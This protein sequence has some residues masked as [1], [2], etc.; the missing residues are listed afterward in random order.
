MIGSGSIVLLAGLLR[1]G[2]EMLIYT[3]Q[4]AS[5]T[6]IVRVSPDEAPLKTRGKTKRDL[7]L[8]DQE[9]LSESRL[10]DGAPATALTFRQGRALYKDRKKQVTVN[11]LTPTTRNLYRLVVEKGRFIDDDDIR[12]RRRVAVV[13]QDVWQDLL[14]RAPSIDGIEIEVEG[15]RWQVIGV[16]KE[17]PLIGGNMGTWMWNRRVCVPNTTFDSLYSTQHQVGA[18]FVRAGAQGGVGDRLAAVKNVVGSTLLRRHLGVKNFRLDGGEGEKTQM[19]IILMVIKVLLLGTGILSLFVGGINIMNIM[20]VTVTE[21]TREIGVR[22][23]V[24]A[25]PSAVLTQFLLEAAVIALTGGII[26]VCGGAFLAWLTAVGL[27]KAFGEWPLHIEAWSVILGLGLSA[28]TGIVFGLFPA[29]RAAR[30]D[31]V[32]ALRYE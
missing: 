12:E 16:L 24:G 2:Q 25:T 20:L 14:E 5:E 1:G 31:P 15:H 6:D 8:Q 29:W 3:E 32:E 19:A 17:K 28:F 18:V 7:S 10:L 26:G 13:G 11:G 23:A 22:R 9:V 4:A 30:L 21:R 27:G